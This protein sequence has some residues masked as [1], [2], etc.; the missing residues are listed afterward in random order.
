MHHSRED[1]LFAADF[2]RY[3]II[4]VLKEFLCTLTAQ[5]VE[6]LLVGSNDKFAENST[7]LFAL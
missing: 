2:C 1:V 6:E 3:K 7:L 5:T 4:S